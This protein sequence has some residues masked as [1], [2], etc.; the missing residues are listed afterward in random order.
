MSLPPQYTKALLTEIDC[1]HEPANTDQQIDQL[2]LSKLDL[3]FE[4]IQHEK[5]E[6]KPGILTDYMNAA[7]MRYAEQFHTIFGVLIAVVSDEDDLDELPKMFHKVYA[8]DQY[9]YGLLD[10]ES[11]VIKLL[12]HI[13]GMENAA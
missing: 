6:G 13:E 12:N 1:I 9:C 5:K 3:V 7:F 4:K 2:I 8:Q 11:K 10:E